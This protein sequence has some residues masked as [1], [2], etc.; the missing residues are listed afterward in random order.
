MVVIALFRGIAPPWIESEENKPE[1]AQLH[2]DE[3]RD[4]DQSTGA[5]YVLNLDRRKARTLRALR[6]REGPRKRN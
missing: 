4:E 3:I 2:T 6:G 1:P 5:K